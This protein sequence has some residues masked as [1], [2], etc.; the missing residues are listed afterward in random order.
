MNNDYF[1]LNEQKQY[2]QSLKRG[3]LYSNDSG[4]YYCGIA[5]THFLLNLKELTK[6]AALKR[7]QAYKHLHACYNKF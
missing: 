3:I 6:Q 4:A 5:I 1:A 2:E 7:I